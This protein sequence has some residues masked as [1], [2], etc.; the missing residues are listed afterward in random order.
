MGRTVTISEEL[1][2]KL[3]LAMQEQGLQSIEQLL[4]LWQAYAVERRRRQ[5]VVHGIDDL[6][7]RFHAKYGDMPDSVPLIREDRSR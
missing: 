2:E 4:E 3:T 7:D 6:R 1:Y 5:E